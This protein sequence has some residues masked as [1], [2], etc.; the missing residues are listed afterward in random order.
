M[1]MLRT[2]HRAITSSSVRL[3]SSSKLNSGASIGAAMFI[4]LKR[5]FSG[6]PTALGMIG[7]PFT[8]TSPS[9]VA[10]IWTVFCSSY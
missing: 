1:L 2:V 6:V 7:A 5:L 4:S 10:I 3:P 9:L 8:W